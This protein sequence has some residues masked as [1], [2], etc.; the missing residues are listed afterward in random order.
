MATFQARVYF[1]GLRGTEVKRLN[2]MMLRLRAGVGATTHDP[3]SPGGDT[4]TGRIYLFPSVEIE[5]V[6][7]FTAWLQDHIQQTIQ[8]PVALSAER[9]DEETG[10]PLAD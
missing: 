3:N 6:T 9:V 8:T 10:L 4:P 1:A 2:R 5:T 7:E